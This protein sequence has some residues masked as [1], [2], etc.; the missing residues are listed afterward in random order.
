MK[1]EEKIS[2]TMDLDNQLSQIYYLFN[3]ISIKSKAIFAVISAQSTEFDTILS[4]HTRGL[5]PPYAR[6]RDR[7]PKLV[8][9]QATKTY[10]Y[11]LLST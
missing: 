3:N 5:E 8:L 1:F 10:A 9:R 11:L 7:A 4:P 2:D 6:C